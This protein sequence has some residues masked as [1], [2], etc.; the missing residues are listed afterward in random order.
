MLKKEK[1][2][3]WRLDFLKLAVESRDCRTRNS[4]TSFWSP[5]KVTNW[6]QMNH[7]CMDVNVESMNWLVSYCTISSGRSSS[8]SNMSQCLF[9]M[10]SVSYNMKQQTFVRSSSVAKALSRKNSHHR[11]IF[12]ILSF[13]VDLYCISELFMRRRSRTKGQVSVS[14]KMWYTTKKGRNWDFPS[15]NSTCSQLI[16][17][18]IYF[19]FT[20]QTCIH[21]IS[22]D[23]S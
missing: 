1:K 20:Q 11:H 3:S 14:L 13:W 6:E 22:F 21:S 12:S 10:Y 5:D 17:I 2:I 16:Y 19:N 9:Y 8:C 4:N 23:F 7:P 15:S 18:Y